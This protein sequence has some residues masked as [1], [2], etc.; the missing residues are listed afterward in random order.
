LGRTKEAVEAASAAIVAWGPRHADRG[1]ALNVLR[2]VLNA[3]QDLDAYVKHLDAEATKSGQDSPILRK[4]VGQ[5]Y[6]S[7][8]EHA[9]AVTQFQLAAALQPLDKEVHQALMTSYDALGQKDEA[10]RQLVK[11]IDFDRHELTLYEQ[12]AE[13]FKEN[14]V[15]AERAA[16]SILEA[17]P[18]EAE[19]HAALA[20]LRE[21]QNRWDE[22][23]PHWRKAAEL[24]R[25]EPTNLV[26]LAEAQI[27]E[28]QWDAARQ[29]IEKLQ[30]TDWP[31]RFSDV[32]PRV[33]EL[34]GQL[35]K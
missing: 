3:S 29:T 15:E 9:K 35:P 17:D 31:A 20:E 27:H 28:K 1:D 18:N 24:R 25:L 16:T 5:V 33:Q 19:N 2:H 30:K 14:E 7:R 11:L 4:A 6:K 23:I 32:G 13:R 12:L 34:Q 22:A 21:K 8:S 26:Q 10:T